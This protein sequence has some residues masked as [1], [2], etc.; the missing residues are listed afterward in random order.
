MIRICEIDIFIQIRKTFT[1]VHKYIGIRKT[2]NW[3]RYETFYYI[4][5]FKVFWHEGRERHNFFLC[6]LF[7]LTPPRAAHFVDP[8]LV[9]PLRDSK[10]QL[11]PSKSETQLNAFFQIP[12]SSALPGM[13]S[14]TSLVQ[15]P[16]WSFYCDISDCHIRPTRVNTCTQLTH[17]VTNPCTKRK[18]L[19][20]TK[21]KGKIYETKN[22]N[23]KKI[24]P[25][26]YCTMYHKQF[27]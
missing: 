19:S 25:Q 18:V 11:S 8:Q 15:F 10:N 14:F 24:P 5:E 7:H 26:I 13:T 27:Y 20:L 9:S 17:A 2:R 16:I 6:W 23:I 12:K 21:P 4:L 22:D 3:F 1:N